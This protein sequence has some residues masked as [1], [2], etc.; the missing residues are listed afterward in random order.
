MKKLIGWIKED[1]Y[2]SLLLLIPLTYAIHWYSE[3]RYEEGLELATAIAIDQAKMMERIEQLNANVEYIMIS[4]EYGK[5][6]PVKFGINYEDYLRMRNG[7][8]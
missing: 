8:N 7:T 3:K 4:E 2:V 5:D 6:I 1:R